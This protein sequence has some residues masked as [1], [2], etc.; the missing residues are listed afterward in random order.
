[1]ERSI[2]ERFLKEEPEGFLPVDKWMAKDTGLETVKGLNSIPY[3]VSLEKSSLFKKCG[4]DGKE[5]FVLVRDIKSDDEK[6]MK[7]H[8]TF[9]N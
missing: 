4:I 3:G 7:N 9:M 8:T 2:A 1:M 6:I 5:F